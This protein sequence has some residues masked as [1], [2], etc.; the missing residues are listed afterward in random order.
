MESIEF[1]DND[2]GGIII[3]PSDGQYDSVIFWF[4]GLGDTAHGWADAI[5]YLNIP[6][7]KLILPNAPTRPISLNYGH[8]MPGWSDIYGLNANDPEDIE[9]FTNSANRINGF[10]EKEVT[11]NNIS[12]SRIIIGGFSQGGALALHLTLRHQ[13]YAFGGCIAFSTWLPFHADYPSALS[14]HASSLPIFQAHGTS[15]TIVPYKW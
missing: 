12:P 13:K 9:G 15:D 2:G 10:I 3:T 5:E 6:K 14:P 11:E 8:S 4:H 1:E 7:A